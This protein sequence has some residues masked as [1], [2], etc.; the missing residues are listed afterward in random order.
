M[1][2]NNR[3]FDRDTWRSGSYKKLIFETASGDRI[4]IAT[5]EVTSQHGRE[6]LFYMWY[7][8]ADKVLTNPAEVKWIE[9]RERL[10]GGSGSG[11]IALRASRLSECGREVAT[12]SSFLKL[13]FDAINQSLTQTWVDDRAMLVVQK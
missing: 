1:N 6:Q 3:L 5:F 4:D 9:L 7:A 13:H 2:Q 8:I 10:S 12:V 11:L